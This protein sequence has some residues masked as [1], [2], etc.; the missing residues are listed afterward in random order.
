M[1]THWK[2]SSNSAVICMLCTW[3]ICTCICGTVWTVVNCQHTYTVYTV[4]WS[5][6]L[7]TLFFFWDELIRQALCLCPQHFCFSPLSA[8][9]IAFS[10]FSACSLVLR[11]TLTHTHTHTHAEPAQ[12]QWS[13]SIYMRFW[14]IYVL[15]CLIELCQVSLCAFVFEIHRARA[16]EWEPEREPKL[17][18]VKLQRVVISVA[19]YLCVFFFCLL[20]LL[21]LWLSLSC[22]CWSAALCVYLC[23]CA[24]V[25]SPRS[26]TLEDQQQQQ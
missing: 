7:C 21:L 25:W 13:F 2:P 24:C 9:C 3:Y 18:L 12:A 20:L 19:F 1:C 15:Y 10:F 14:I 17:A 11:H 6:K 16:R 22:V 23:V 5:V 4:H 26:L 8:V